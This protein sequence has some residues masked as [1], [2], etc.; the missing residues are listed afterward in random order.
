[1]LSLGILGGIYAFENPLQG[2]L[3]VGWP[4]AARATPLPLRKCSSGCWGG[5]LIAVGLAVAH[6]GQAIDC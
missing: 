5:P 2:C 4:G 6:D 3:L 1:M